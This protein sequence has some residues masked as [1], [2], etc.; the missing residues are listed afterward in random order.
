MSEK[1]EHA[2]R[3]FIAEAL[4]RMKAEK[5]GIPGAKVQQFLRKLNE[6]WDRLGQ[7]SEEQI[8]G[9]FHQFVA[10]AHHVSN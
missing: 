3:A 7:L 8:R 10:E 4:R 6:E 1:M 2:E 9:L 5:P